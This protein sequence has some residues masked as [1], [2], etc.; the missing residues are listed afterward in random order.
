M[1]RRAEA[2]RFDGV[3]DVEAG[4]NQP[5][6][7]TVEDAS[8][9]EAEV[10]LKPSAR[11]ELGVE[12]LANEVLAAC[13]AGQLGLPICEPILVEMTPGWI[14]TIPDAALRDVLGRSSPVAFGSRSAG[15]GW[16]GWAAKDHVL[17]ERRPVATAIFFFI[18]GARV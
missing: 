9:E 2:V 15:P 17:G 3:V 14:A 5:L 4:R 6:M 11:P 7:V 13:V 16:K 12:G 10:F 18:S 8:G 1:I